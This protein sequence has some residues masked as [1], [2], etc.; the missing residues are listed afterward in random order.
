M[1][2]E[3]VT[4]RAWANRRNGKICVGIKFILWALD[5]PNDSSSPC[6]P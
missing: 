1:T 4:V 5:V 2:D 3:Y 6:V